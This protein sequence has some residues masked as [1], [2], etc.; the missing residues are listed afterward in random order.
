MKAVADQQITHDLCRLLDHDVPHRFAPGIL[1]GTITDI[2]ERLGIGYPRIVAG[3]IVIGDPSMARYLLSAH[4]DEASFSVTVVGD[5]TV[6]L[7][8]CHRFP[9]G[10]DRA[11][12]RF[13]GVRDGEYRN[14]GDAEIRS[15]GQQFI[16][17]TTT[18]IRLGDRA[19][20]RHPT[21]VEA[22]LVTAK[23]ID[24]RVGAL[25]ALHGARRLLE[26]GIPTA[27]VLSDGEQ[28]RPTGYF[29]RTFPHVLHTLAAEATI[30]FLD[31]IFQD[32]LRRD[33]VT[34]PL[35]GALVVPHSGDGAGYSVAPHT[36]AILR[37]MII[38]EAVDAGIDVRISGA[39][40]SRGDDWGMV[41]NPTCGH[42]H[43]AFFLSFGGWGNTPA[44]RTIDLACIG[45]C[46][47]FLEFAA[48]RFG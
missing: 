31:G 47:D 25:I 13:V 27:V 45:N 42:E 2:C 15:A 28:N 38:P 43:S 22:N 12:I 41:T 21:T 3:N 26:L 14:L 9:G 23:A 17:H 29:S 10:L 19:V 7:A 18:D 37:D 46:V 44:H 8:P 16:T 39:Y 6:T 24:D 48:E 33:G 20:Y 1:T 11:D 4:L 35:P 5:S 30:V 32:G 40:H 34:G 36:F